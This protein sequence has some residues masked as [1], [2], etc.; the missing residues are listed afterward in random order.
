MDRRLARIGGVLVL[1]LWF[2]VAIAGRAI[3]FL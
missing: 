1:T 3:G 2:G